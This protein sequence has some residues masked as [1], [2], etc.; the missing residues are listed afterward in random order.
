[1]ELHS[2]FDV[3]LTEGSQSDVK[4]EAEENIIPH[5]DLQV[6][7]GI[8][9]IDSEDNIWLRPKRKIKIYVTSPS[10]SR[11]Q[12]TGSGDITSQMRISNDSKM[13]IDLTGSGDLKLD[14]DAPEVSA[15]VTGS[16]GIKLSGE[17]QKLYARCYWQ[18][19]YQSYGPEG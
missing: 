16:G 8:L 7:N 1:M 13:N 19:R 2:S 10:F 18:R 12:N 4:I 6:V 14:V 17:T 15:S 3:F 11:I 5:I 9:N